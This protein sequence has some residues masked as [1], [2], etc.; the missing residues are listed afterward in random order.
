MTDRTAVFQLLDRRRAETVEL[1][2]TYI[3]QPS[4]SLEKQALD[5]GAVFTA[6]ALRRA[7]CTEAEVID[8]GDGY[9]GVYGRLDFGKPK[10]LLIYGHY[11]VRPEGVE[12]WTHD[13]FSGA[14]TPFDGH[15]SVVM[16]RG[17]AVKAPFMAFLATIRAMI[18]TEASLPVNLVFL[19]EGAE[20][21]GSPNYIGLVEA[22]PG[23]LEGVT[24]IFGPRAGQGPDGT[25]GFSLGY[26]GL[27]Y[28]DLVAS[29]TTWGK[30]PDGGSIHS[31]TNVVV[32]NPAWRL[33]AALS[34]L[35]DTD[36]RILVP[37]LAEA[38]AAEK[39]IEAWEAPMVADLAARLE[40]NPNAVLPGLNTGFPV[41]QFRDGLTGETLAK[42]YLY[43]AAMNVSSLRAGYTGPGTKSF[44]LPHEAIATLD[45]RAI[46]DTPA[47]ELIAMLRAHLDAGGF[48]DIEVVTR[49]AYDWNQTAPDSDLIRAATEVHGDMGHPVKTWPIQAFGGPWAHYGKV[50]GVPSLQGGAAGHGARAATSDEY[51]VL[52]GHD[53]VAGL[54]GLERFYV[55]FLDR[56]GAS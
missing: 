45:L 2:T 55:D 34:T 46:T 5:S 49:G 28:L 27:V 32:D 18:E 19:I 21:L 56:Y 39:P 38:V 53:K 54:A 29:G 7:G 11:D 42:R 47:R 33:I 3:Q 8:I 17:A 16:G 20:I 4:V 24:G 9:P 35:V 48:A 1:I 13:P 37:A 40:A 25:V 15:D 10:T 50:L 43:G 51:F 23:A 30:G 44:L 41:R 22:R 6:D 12:P 26:K 14:V 52:E 31:A 36:S